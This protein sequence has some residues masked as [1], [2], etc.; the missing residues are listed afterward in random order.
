MRGEQS[1]REPK[2]WNWDRSH[3]V[4]PKNE[5]SWREALVGSHANVGNWVCGVVGAPMRWDLLV[6]TGQFLT[7]IRGHLETVENG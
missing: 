1:I 3:T 2:T 4:H 5:T 6:G 7:V